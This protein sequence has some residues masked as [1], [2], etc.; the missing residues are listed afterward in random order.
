MKKTTTGFTIVELLIVVVVIAI[1]AAVSMVAYTGI[2]GRARD[3]QRLQ[4]MNTIVKALEMYRVQNGRY[5]NAVATQPTATIGGY[6]LSAG[7]DGP[8][9]FLRA[10]VT[11]NTISQVPVDPI[12]QHVSGGVNSSNRIYVYIRMAAGSWGCDASKGAFYI[13]AIQRMDT[14]AVGAK[15]STSPG[16]TCPN[17]NPTYMFAWVTGRFE[18]E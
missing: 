2:Q 7:P 8:T 14:V 17:V 5:P 1:L 11:S 12:N 3:S 9:D 10:L 15:H 6:E 16:F 18:N 4:D 13:V